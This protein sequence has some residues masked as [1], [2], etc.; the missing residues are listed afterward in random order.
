[1]CSRNSI[2]WAAVWALKQPNLKINAL[3]FINT[4]VS[5]SQYLT[6]IDRSAGN[7]LMQNSYRKYGGFFVIRN[8][9]PLK[10]FKA[11]FRSNPWTTPCAHT[12]SP[13]DDICT[14]TYNA[15]R[16]QQLLGLSTLPASPTTTAPPLPTSRVPLAYVSDPSPATET[17]PRSRTD[18]P[19]R[20]H[21]ETGGF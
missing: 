6:Y 4:S 1:M 20:A 3:N 14:R 11:V 16:Q 5:L 12:H 17:A 10:C 9:E 19:R 13:I 21:P 18:S 15:H 7:S 8:V 2:G